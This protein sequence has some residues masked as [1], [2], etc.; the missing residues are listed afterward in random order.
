MGILLS[1]LCLHDPESRAIVLRSL[2]PLRDG[3]K[4]KIETLLSTV[5]EFGTILSAVVNTVGKGEDGSSDG[6]RGEVSEDEG[7]R[8]AQ[9][10]TEGLESLLKGDQ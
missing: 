1:L 8:L 10:V 9:T 6:G 7:I 2:Q 4:E 5:R 3:D